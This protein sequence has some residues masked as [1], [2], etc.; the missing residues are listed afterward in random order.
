MDV[1]VHEITENKKIRELY[2]ATGGGWGG[3][4]VDEAY[5]KFLSSLLSTEKKD[6]NEFNTEKESKD[7][8]SRFQQIQS[9][10]YLD[11]KDEWE[12][13]KCSF[14]DKRKDCVLKL[15][16]SL[17][18]IREKL[19]DKVEIDTRSPAFKGKVILKGNRLRLTGELMQSFFETSVKK[20]IDHLRKLLQFECLINVS[21][22]FMAG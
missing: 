5:E 9:E 7:V 13:R 14:S 19:K 6:G 20:T 12:S 18:T 2:Y 15:P 22:I 3:T 16:S 17:I 11:M 1:A 4:L 10:D 21:V 8:L